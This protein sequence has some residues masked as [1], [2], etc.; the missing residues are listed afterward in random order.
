MANVV[1]EA[2]RCMSCGGGVEVIIDKCATCLTC[3]RVCP[4]DIPVVTDV[5]RISS[6]KCQACGLCMAECPANAIIPRSYPQDKLDKQIASALTGDAKTLVFI[7]GF[8]R[9]AAEWRGEVEAIDGVAEIYLTST[10]RLNVSAILKALQCGA[11][12]VIVVSCPEGSDRYP[13]VAVRTK[14]HVTQVRELISEIG[15]SPESVQLIEVGD[16]DRGV[17][18]EAI[19]EAMKDK[20]EVTE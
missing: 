1:I 9:P 13:T 15:L 3:L 6:D 4:F 11:Q 5:A 12:R 14:R 7:G 10:S 17:I 18:T 20:E 2:R 8:C 16:K 19:I